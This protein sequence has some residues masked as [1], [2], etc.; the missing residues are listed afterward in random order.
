VRNSW[1]INWGNNG[2]FIL[3]RGNT[4]GVCDFS[5]VPILEFD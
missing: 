1:G 2:Y 4:C 5:F 3:G